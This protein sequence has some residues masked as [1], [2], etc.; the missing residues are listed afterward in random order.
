MR[1]AMTDGWA[2]PASVHQAGRRARALVERARERIAQLLG[3]EA[4]DV[5][6]TS[7]G[8][9]ANNLALSAASGLVTSRIEHPSVVRVGEA[10]ADRD[11]PVRWLPARADGRIDSDDV[12]AAVATLPSGATVA[13]SAA[14]HETGVIQPIRE[15]SEV[16]HA[17]GGRL[18]VDAV[19]AVG[20]VDP[21]LWSGA[22]SVSL[23][24]H[25]I[26][27]PKGI[28]VLS[29]RPGWAPRPVLVGGAQERGLRPGT[30]DA[31]AAVGLEAA[32][33]RA[34]TGPERHAQIAP[35]RDR[36]E[37]ALA[38]WGEVNGL[39]A[40]RLPHVSNLSFPGWRGDELAAALDLHGIRVSSG[41]ACSAGTQEISP[42]V[43]AMLGR[44][45]AASAIRI[46]LGDETDR[47]AADAA[48][49]VFEAVLTARS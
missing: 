40:P 43:M 25:K 12:H 44:E 28:G 45:R 19:Q 34:A 9:E 7:G 38:R 23:S 14:N 8:T 21:S 24:A 41:S 2:N 3:F 17:G 10:L 26:R 33:S 4:R 11:V 48:V 5:L 27:G 49:E 36:I 18:H 37:K 42:V 30:V 1:A 31:V 20:K 13:L 29:W 22:D 16:V 6:L 47:A 15:V 32:V 35:L 46:S 39:G